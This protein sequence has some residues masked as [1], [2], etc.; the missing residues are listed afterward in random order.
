MAQPPSTTNSGTSTW[1]TIKVYHLK[2]PSF[3]LV[4]ALKSE[5]EHSTITAACAKIVGHDHTSAVDLEWR[6][7]NFGKPW[8]DRFEIVTSPITAVGASYEIVLSTQASERLLRAG[9]GAFVALTKSKSKGW[10]HPNSLFR[11]VDV[12]NRRREEEASAGERGGSTS[13]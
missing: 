8:S 6:T 4:K 9:T 2:A 10:L 7:E 5:G 13:Y 3:I 11:V 1:A 12:Y